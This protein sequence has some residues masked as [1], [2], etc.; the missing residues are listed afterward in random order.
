MAT[1]RQPTVQQPT[2]TRNNPCQK[3]GSA[4]V[5]TQLRRVVVD[6]GWKLTQI[7]A[8]APCQMCTRCGNNTV[9]VTAVVGDLANLVPDPDAPNARGVDQVPKA[10]AP[11]TPESAKKVKAA[12]QRKRKAELKAAQA[13][14]EAVKAVDKAAAQKKRKAAAKARRRK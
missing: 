4:D 8:I 3:C 6:V 13:K 7:R 9:T 11:K 14:A 2:A 5:I 10:G 1:K 12:A